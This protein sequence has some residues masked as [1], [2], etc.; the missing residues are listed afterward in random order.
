MDSNELISGEL[1]QKIKLIFN[2]AKLKYSF[3]EYPL[4]RSYE[5]LKENKEKIC[6]GYK[7]LTND[8]K[9]I[10]N[11]SLPFYNDKKN[12]IVHRKEDNRFE[13]NKTL[14]D[15]LSNFDLLLLLKIKYSYGEY[16]DSKI[17]S[18]KKHNINKMDDSNDGVTGFRLTYTDNLGMLK[19]IENNRADYMIMA[20]N[21]FEYFEKEYKDEKLNLTYK[22]LND[23]NKINQRAFLC[24]KKVTK[25]ELD[26]INKSIIKVVGKL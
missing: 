3:I 14:S 1:Y 5:E 25:L 9:D 7:I 12:I 10:G 22:Y 16:E 4:A 13:E 8:K 11:Y 20:L 6:I 23:V 24:S 17:S 2:N 18:I 26:K 21:E 19:Q 15:Y